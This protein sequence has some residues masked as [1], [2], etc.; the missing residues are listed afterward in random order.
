MLPEDAEPSALAAAGE[1]DSGD[2]S[3]GTEQ[4]E[5]RGNLNTMNVISAN[6][7]GLQQRAQSF[8]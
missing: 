3:E 6:L 2:E 4:E 1:G 5:G 8:V 7:R